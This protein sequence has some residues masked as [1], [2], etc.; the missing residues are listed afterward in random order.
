MRI[1]I[2]LQRPGGS[3]ADLA[4]TADA[5]TR[6]SNIAD[7]LYAADPQNAAA[8]AAAAATAAATA[9]TATTTA[10][11]AP[12]RPPR[13]TLQVTGPSGEPRLLDPESNLLESGFRSGSV[14][15]LRQF[16]DSFAS[17]Q[18]RGPSAATLRVLSGPDAGAE[19]EL[20]FGSSHIGRE[21]GIDV[22]LS[23]TLVSKRHARINIGEN[24]EIIDLNSA[25]G[26]LMGGQQVART[27]LGPAD[28]V[29]LGDTAV[30]VIPLQR[31]G[32]AAPSTPVI[33][34]NRSPR[35]VARYPGA[36]Y[37]APAPPTRPQA[38]RFPLIA[39]IA[40]LIMG[41]VLFA[42][43]QSILSVVFVALSPLLMI[44]TYID[45]RITTR[46]QLRDAIKAFTQSLNTYV[47][48]LHDRQRV[49]R[50]VRLTEAP[51]VADTVE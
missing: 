24:V 39:L 37:P 32:G 50:A 15:E 42:V 47:S 19:F 28:V 13:L 25:N 11:A 43:T 12:T 18:G 48:R 30:S 40:P 3:T 49:Q 31:L 14:V 22:R 41:A 36:E 17:G 26:L 16:S 1:K 29:V 51:A 7:A 44:G 4:V 45:H 33:E 2:T 23:D 6:V 10:G 21:R 5:T 46:R 38:Q 27:V 35:V 8:A 20:P 9:A 34:Y